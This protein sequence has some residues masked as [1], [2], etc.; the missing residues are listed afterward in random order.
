MYEHNDTVD[1]NFILILYLQRNQ[2]LQEGP[3]RQAHVIDNPV[4]RDLAGNLW[5]RESGA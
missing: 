1:S 4:L 5:T 3:P 2:R